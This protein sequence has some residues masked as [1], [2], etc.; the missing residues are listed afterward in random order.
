MKMARPDTRPSAPSRALPSLDALRAFAAAA[1][2]GSF[3]EAAD[4]L[5]VTPTAISHRI[6]G[7][8]AHLGCEL[9]V[10]RTRAVE[11][12]GEGRILFEAVQ[13]GLDLMVDA[14]ARIRAPARHRVTISVTPELASRWLVPR[15][16][17]FQKSCPD[18]DLHVHASHDTADLNGGCADLAIRYGNGRF[19]GVASIPLFQERFAPVASP[20]LLA[21]LPSAPGRWPLIHMQWHR[22][23]QQAFDWARWAVAAGIDPTTMSAGTLYSDGAHAT[24]AAIAGQGVALLGLGLL[25]D[26][27]RLNRLQIVAEPVLDAPFYHVCT[28][29]RRPLSAAASRV[30][31]WLLGQARA[32]KGCA[33]TGASCDDVHEMSAQVHP[34]II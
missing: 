1:R 11:L 31:E 25:E 18:I 30:R 22:K 24:Q 21:C 29:S 23:T 8:E 13:N 32:P 2:A 19:S 12:S 15:L 3:K 10:R 20:A 6:R 7:L 14:I 17:D 28:P 16:A 34:D 26:E 4:A 5:S 9:F 27:L 33:E